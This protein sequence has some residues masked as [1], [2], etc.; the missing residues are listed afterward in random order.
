MSPWTLAQGVLASG[1]EPPRYFTLVDTGVTYE[2]NET[3]AEVVMLLRGGA[4]V[5]GAAAAL[6]R[7]HPDAPREEVERDVREVVGECERLGLL[8]RS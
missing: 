6:A 7:R 1:G 3:A 4:D 8:S 2:L 5:G